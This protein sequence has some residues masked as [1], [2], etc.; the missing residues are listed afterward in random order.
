MA[1]PPPPPSATPKPKRRCDDR[2]HASHQHLSS[3][4]AADEVRFGCRD[5]RFRFRFV[6]AGNGSG[7]TGG[8]T[9]HQTPAPQ[10]ETGSPWRAGRAGR[11]G[12][13]GGA[14]RRRWWSSFFVFVFVWFGLVDAFARWDLF[15]LLFTRG[16]HEEEDDEGRGGVVEEGLRLEVSFFCGT[17]WRC[18]ELAG[19]IDS[20]RAL[21]VR[22]R[23]RE[24]KQKQQR[25]NGSRK[26]KREKEETKAPPQLYT[27][28]SDQTHTQDTQESTRVVPTEREQE[29][30]KETPH[31]HHCHHH[32][33]PVCL[34]ACL[35]S[36]T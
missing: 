11:S 17:R 7:G 3:A 9:S 21:D 25:Y 29:E 4:A 10:F 36:R 23:E 24:R 31:H 2:G 32:R 5:C 13:G 20:P 12:L 26:K 34:S 28:P 33:V 14:S 22:E 27:N 19:L 8:S 18:S 30:K 1:K 16:D 15:S 35:P 6:G